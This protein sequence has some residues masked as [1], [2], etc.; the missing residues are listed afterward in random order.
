MLL[1]EL[2]EGEIGVI[3]G[4]KGYG[5]FKKRLTEM[6][7]IRGKEVKVVRYA[8]LKDPIEYCIMNYDVSLRLS[9]A[10]LVEVIPLTDYEAKIEQFNGSFPSEEPRATVIRE[11]KVINVALVGT[12]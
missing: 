7:F 4:I 1:S 2:K 9:E 8:P 3:V 5:A 12:L 11:E 6:G 10:S